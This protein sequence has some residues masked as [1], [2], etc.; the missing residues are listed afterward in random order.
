MPKV[1]AS[2]DTG[3]VWRRWSELPRDLPG[4]IPFRRSVDGIQT[5]R[6]VSRAILSM[7]T[8]CSVSW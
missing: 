4:R 2:G 3:A 5:A 7:G 1:I 8:E 6:D